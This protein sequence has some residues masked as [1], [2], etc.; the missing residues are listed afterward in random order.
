VKADVEALLARGGRLD[1]VSFEVASHPALHPG[2]SARI[3][4]A[5]R[6]A[7]WLGELHPALAAELELPGTMLFELSLEALIPSKPSFA[8]FSQLPAVRRDIAMVVTRDIPVASLLARVRATTPPALL[9][10]AFVFDIYTGPQVGNAEKSVAIGLILQDTSRTLTD[11]E[12]NGVLQEVTAA[13]GREF[14]ARIRQ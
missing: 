9:R 12:A 2:R 10:D 3:R 11:E 7:G 14:K 6:D 5:G 13:L 1:A 8:G 4:V